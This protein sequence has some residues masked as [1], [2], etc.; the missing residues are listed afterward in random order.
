M[1]PAACSWVFTSFPGPFTATNDRRRA[2]CPGGKNQSCAAIWDTMSRCLAEPFD[3]PEPEFRFTTVPGR[4][5]KARAHRFL[6]P[7]Q[8]PAQT[9]QD[10]DLQ[11]LLFVQDVAPQCGGYLPCADVNVLRPVYRWPVFRGSSMAAVGCSPR[12]TGIPGSRKV[13]VSELGSYCC[14][15]VPFSASPIS[16]RNSRAIPFTQ[17]YR[18]TRSNQRNQHAESACTICKW[19]MYGLAGRRAS[20]ILGTIR[21]RCGIWRAGPRSQAWTGLAAETSAGGSTG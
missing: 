3:F 18:L 15:V 21:R 8:R 5:F 2:T 1:K 20:P 12:A 4:R 11:F 10:Y 6:D 16:P 14:T 17:P 19:T 13:T 7:P 9:S